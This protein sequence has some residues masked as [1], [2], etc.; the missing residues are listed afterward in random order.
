MN[1]CYKKLIFVLLIFILFIQ[2]NIAKNS[3]IDIDFSG[4]AALQAGE[5]V[6]G[7]Y[8]NV[9]INNRW[10]QKVLGG[11]NLK[12][13]I[14]NN[15]NVEFGPECIFTQAIYD[16][17]SRVNYDADL[18][19]S[20]AFY[21]FYLNKLL[22]SYNFGDAE[23]PFVKISLGYFPFSY[24][25]DVKSLGEYLF[26]ATAYPGYIIN[27]FE[28]VYKRLSGLHIYSHPIKGLNINLLLTSE[29]QSPVG[30]FTPSFLID[31][32]IGKE[33]NN[34]VFTIG[35][36]I[37]GTR[38]IPV[39]P[40]LTTPHYPSNL[41]VINQDTI[42]IQGNDSIAA[43]DSITP[44]D[45]IYYSFS[46][47]KLMTRFSFDIKKLF[48]GLS[49]LGE[50]D[51][52]IYAEACI[53]GIKDYPVFYDD[54]GRRIPIMIGINLPVFK[55]L[56]VLSCEAEWYNSKYSNNYDQTYTPRNKAPLPVVA[57]EPKPYPWYWSIYARKTIITGLQIMGEI[58]RNH[59]FMQC[60]YPQYQDRREQTPNHGDWQFIIRAQYYF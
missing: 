11:M 14:N 5:I 25:K 22:G 39:D 10:Q 9:K 37:S 29:L 2:K 38:L 56:D 46:A 55:L 16:N 47:I 8:K 21:L 7:Q 57:N 50:E 19:S 35:A 43:Y 58:G 24:N 26:R 54:I 27:D 51:L 18:E 49:I 31:Y 1:Y 28:S 52:K 17:P 42:H 40:S 34:A 32:S 13:T 41:M 23:N 44:G 6:R 20:H 12:A 36:G 30:D 45:S 59:Y 60:K 3:N 33:E 4:Y 15:L 48:G 53:L